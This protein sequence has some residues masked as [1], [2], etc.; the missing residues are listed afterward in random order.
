VLVETLVA[1]GVKTETAGAVV[2][3]G[4]ADEVWLEM[5]GANGCTALTRDQ[6]IRYRTIEKQALKSYKV[7]AFTFTGGQATGQQTADRVMALLP[8]LKAI[9]ISTP[10]PF[11]YT[12]GLRG[13]IATVKLR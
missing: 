9:A 2:S 12:F 7:G 6:R 1:A 5:C 8:K 4:A 10:R 3:F 11:L 13:P